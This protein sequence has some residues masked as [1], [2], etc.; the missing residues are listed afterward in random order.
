MLANQSAAFDNRSRQQHIHH[1]DQK[2][3]V[4]TNQRYFPD[5]AG[6]KV[7]ATVLKSGDRA[8]GKCCI[9]EARS[10]QMLEKSVSRED[11]GHDYAQSSAQRTSDPPFFE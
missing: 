8:T 6:E 2:F 5:L 4:R 7:A 11:T 10:C 1:K 9:H 3:L